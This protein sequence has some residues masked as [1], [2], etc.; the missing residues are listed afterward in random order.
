V[1]RVKAPPAGG[2]AGLWVGVVPVVVGT[3]PGYSLV[4]SV[5]AERAAAWSTMVL[6]AA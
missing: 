6:L 2:Q 3:V 4:T 5:T 1:G